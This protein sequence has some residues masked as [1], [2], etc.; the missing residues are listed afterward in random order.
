MKIANNITIIFS[1]VSFSSTVLYEAFAFQT[2]TRTSIPATRRNDNYNCNVKY[3]TAA[4]SYSFR[5][6]NSILLSLSSTSGYFGRK[7]HEGNFSGGRLNDSDVDVPE[8]D[9]GNAKES[10]ALPSR[11]SRTK[12]GARRPST[13]EE[14]EFRS[15]K[16]EMKQKERQ[17]KLLERKRD[18]L[19]RMDEKRQLQKEE[20]IKQKEFERE[21]FLA[22]KAEKEQ[23]FKEKRLLLEKEAQ[24]RHEANLKAREEANAK[25]QLRIEKLEKEKE[26]RVLERQRVAKEKLKAKQEALVKAQE[27]KALMNRQRLYALR[28]KQKQAAEDIQINEL[29]LN[30]KVDIVE[31]FA[32]Q[33]SNTVQEL[34]TIKDDEESFKKLVQEQKEQSN[35]CRKQK[36]HV[37][38]EINRLQFILKDTETVVGQL[39]A[40]IDTI[41]SETDVLQEVIKKSQT[42]M[43]KSNAEEKQRY[44]S[45]FDRASAMLSNKD[46]EKTKIEN[47][48]K[49]ALTIAEL[50]DKQVNDAMQ[51]SNQL[52]QEISTLDQSIEDNTNILRNVVKAKLTLQDKVK[53]DKVAKKKLLVE[54][55]SMDKQL[56]EKKIIENVNI[57]KGKRLLLDPDIDLVAQNDVALEV[58]QETE[59]QDGNTVLVEEKTDIA[60]EVIK[61]SVA[62]NGNTDLQNVKDV[63]EKTDIAHE[64]IKDA[65]PA[66]TPWTTYASSVISYPKQ[67]ISI[68]KTNNKTAKTSTQTKY[69]YAI[70]IVE[71]K[72]IVASY[73]TAK[74]EPK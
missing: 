20:A 38:Q 51:E 31:E 62:L 74:V 45:V 68:P 71:K 48:L 63:E 46:K 24:E 22:L 10:R 23:K 50:T 58:P 14:Y 59:V 57:E 2:I 15:S 16:I 8:A 70:S 72:N 6:N 55:S 60:Q 28:M 32:T 7:K 9:D 1:L 4:A 27:E 47:D 43:D 69:S 39:K 54:I 41:Q 3:P 66:S 21:R 25:E 34:T 42:A 30:Q 49:G 44:E 11:R 13:K 53:S 35:K 36:K 56:N 18:A 12:V 5:R 19:K 29:K 73:Q 52:S 67:S 26:A 40:H 65:I 33:Q 61:E 37:A 64:V 17:Q